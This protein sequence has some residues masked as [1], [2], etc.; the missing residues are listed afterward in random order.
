MLR[1]AVG[2]CLEH[3]LDYLTAF[4]R[5]W[6]ATFLLDAAISVFLRQLILSARPWGLSDPKS[7]GLLGVGAFNLVRRTAFEATEGFQWLRMET[8]DDVAL[9]LMM[10][11]SGARC[12]IVSAFD[13]LALHWYRSLAEAARGAEKGYASV[14]HFSVLRAAIGAAVGLA[15]EL[16]PVLT[17]VPLIFASVRPAGYVGLGVLAAFVFS[18]VAVTRWAGARVLPALAGPVVAPLYAVLSIRAAVLGRRRGGVLW[19]GTL[20]REQHLRRGMRIRLPLP[21]RRIR[22]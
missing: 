8:A 2:F 14:Y 22:R 9:A 16:S 5:L 7:S 21:G 12:A 13:D 3:R 11:D 1:R 18:V 15:L 20:Y 19:R 17:L 4:P 10:K 6:P